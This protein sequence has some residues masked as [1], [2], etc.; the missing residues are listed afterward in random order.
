MRKSLLMLVAILLGLSLLG[1]CQSGAKPDDGS[2][3]GPV[4]DPGQAAYPA[5]QIQPTATARAYPGPDGPGQP[6]G[7]PVRENGSIMNVEVLS[8][9]QSEKNP[10]FVV[11]HVKVNAT[12]PAPGLE[13]Y[14]PNLASQEI[15]I[16]LRV[17]D[18]VGLA[19]GDI[20]RLT[21][22]YRGDEW[23]GGYYGSN[24]NHES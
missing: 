3:E 23:G 22:S 11:I 12:T 7:A 5:P 9:A 17:G 19:P 24:I 13:E 15:D 4:T 8:L 18:A 6:A 1:G 2:G 14:D 21:V 10:D 16:N 20:L